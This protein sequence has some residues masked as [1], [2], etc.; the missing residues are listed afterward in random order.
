MGKVDHFSP[1][2]SDKLQCYVYRLI[3]PRSGTTFYVG[4]G[5]GNRVFSHAAGDEKCETP[6]EAK[7]MKMD[8]IRDIKTA[9]FQVEH[10]I[11][12]HGMSVETAKEVEAA[13]IDAYPG[14]TNIQVG[15]DSNRR[16]KH[17]KQI[18]RQYEPEEANFTHKVILIK[19]DQS[20]KK[21]P[22]ISIVDAVRYAWKISVTRAR[23]ADYVLAVSQGMIVG[24]FIARDWRLATRKDFPE[25]PPIDP[26]RF[27][28]S[29]SEAPDGVKAMYIQK[30][31]P[32]LK[33]GAAFPIQ[34]VPKTPWK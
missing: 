10:V 30:L 18:I 31:A 27:G 25:F 4:R 20:L 34:Y 8:L 11:H 13:L 32:K 2:V 22:T 5:Q 26:N 24:V 17:A 28:F 9:D 33:R 1:V 29:A 16:A 6:E 23:K 19:I 7:S 15:Y 14:L 3:D 21:D 12:R